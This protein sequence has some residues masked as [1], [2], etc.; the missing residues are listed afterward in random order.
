[1]ADDAPQAPQ[2]GPGDAHAPSRDPQRSPTPHSD[3]HTVSDPGPASSTPLSDPQP[4]PRSSNTPSASCSS[5]AMADSLLRL[6]DCPLCHRTLTA[7]TTLHCGHSICTAHLNPVTHVCPVPL[8]T[9]HDVSSPNIPA[10]STVDYHPAP[11]DPAVPPPAPTRVD[12]TITKILDLL[13]NPSPHP[14]PQSDD[15]DHDDAPPPSRTRPRA[16]S[17]DRPRKRPRHHPPPSDDDEPQEDDDLLSH[18]LVQSARQRLTRHDQPLLPPDPPSHQHEIDA[19]F[20]KHL[21]TELTCEICFTL[22]YQPITT[23][24]QHASLQFFPSPLSAHPLF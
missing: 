10:S 20:T 15:D 16:L 22:F 4:N 1:M 21:L 24:C 7:P 18:L 19:R 23:P 3:D 14:Q 11:V 17:D 9:P 5:A 8:C 6:L 13:H 12:V 2:A